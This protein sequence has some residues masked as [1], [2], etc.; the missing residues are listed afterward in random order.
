MYMQHHQKLDQPQISRV[1]PKLLAVRCLME[2]SGRRSSFALGERL[3]DHELGAQK[4]ARLVPEVVLGAHKQQVRVLYSLFRFP[5]VKVVT[6]KGRGVAMRTKQ[7][8]TPVFLVYVH[9]STCV[10]EEHFL[11]YFRRFGNKY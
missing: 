1:T 9:L 3:Q 11:T 2:A 10:E 4:S 6:A 7:P 8:K 5:S